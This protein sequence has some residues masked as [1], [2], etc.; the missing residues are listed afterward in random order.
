MRYFNS[1]EEAE[2]YAK[3]GDYIGFRYEHYTQQ[4]KWAVMNEQER[5]RT[6]LQSG[7]KP[8]FDTWQRLP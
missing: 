5:K 1:L 8:G 4:T 7:Y 6:P 3:S 2:K